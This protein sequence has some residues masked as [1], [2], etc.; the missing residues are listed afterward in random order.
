MWRSS[1]CLSCSANSNSA[2][3]KSGYPPPH[4]NSVVPKVHGH[5]IVLFQWAGSLKFW[6]VTGVFFFVKLRETGK[7]VFKGRCYQDVNFS[8][9]LF[10]KLKILFILFILISITWNFQK[11][12]ISGD[13]TFKLSTYLYGGF[14]KK[15]RNNLICLLFMPMPFFSKNISYQS[16]LR[17]F[18]AGI[19]KFICIIGWVDF[20]ESYSPHRQTSFCLA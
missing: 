12:K 11:E 20:Y 8:V 5:V 13:F 14:V 15:Q 16:R 2:I 6:S 18:E 9:F 4:V 10:L 1:K 19:P 3:R 7:S 17:C